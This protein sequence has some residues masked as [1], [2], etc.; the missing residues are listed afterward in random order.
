[1]NSAKIVFPIVKEK[2]KDRKSIKTIPSIVNEYDR[3]A[4]G[5]ILIL[6]KNL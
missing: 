4:H 1:M 5:K 3:F 2:N 6:K